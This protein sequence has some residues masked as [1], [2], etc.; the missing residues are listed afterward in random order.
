MGAGHSPELWEIYSF[1]NFQ[2]FCTGIVEI[3]QNYAVIQNTFSLNKNLKINFRVRIGKR[4]ISKVHCFTTSLLCWPWGHT[5]LNLILHTFIQAAA[6][7]IRVRLTKQ[8]LASRLQAHI[9]RFISQEA[10]AGCTQLTPSS[11][12]QTSQIQIGMNEQ[13]GAWVDTALA[14][15]KPMQYNAN[16]CNIMQINVI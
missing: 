1:L 6:Q 10:S 5:L 8:G 7:P 16:Q 14:A 13:A 15:G 4:L 11:T 2:T 12:F 9:E 3:P